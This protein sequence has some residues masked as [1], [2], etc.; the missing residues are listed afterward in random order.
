MRA[1]EYRLLDEAVEMGV[2]RG[3]NRA[4]KHTDAPTE[5]QIK[6]SI[7]NAVMGAICEW[8]IFDEVG[9]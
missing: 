4:F 9:E 7:H 6:D 3:Y 8:F 1:N 2:T 5:E